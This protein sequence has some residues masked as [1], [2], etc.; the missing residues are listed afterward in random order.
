MNSK[1]LRV[2][3][4]LDVKGQN[5][6]KGVNLE[7]LRVIGDP[8]EFALKYYNENADEILYIDP[9]AS[10]YGRSKLTD[11]IKKSCKNIFI[12]ITVGG[13]IKNLQD[14]ED[15][16]KS[17]ADKVAVNTGI[18]NNNSLIKDIA[19]T[20]GSQCIVGSIEA[21]LIS[22]DYW[23]IFTDSGRER[24]YINAITWSKKIEDLGVGEILVT[25]IDKEGTCK[26]FDIQLINNIV[27][28]TTVPIIA[29]GGFGSLDH[30]NIIEKIPDLD[31]LAFADSIHYNKISL[32]EIKEK[33]NKNYATT[34]I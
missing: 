15:L 34:R 2:I 7:G 29:S 21:K 17:G 24:T 32:Y 10:L 20:F 31:A 19:K 1:T 13:G 25:S 12:P 5:L 30:L 4:R 26:G 28:S 9:V 27:N 11:I 18:V 16:L 8:N 33:I 3:A 22:E 14:V 23:E 6:I